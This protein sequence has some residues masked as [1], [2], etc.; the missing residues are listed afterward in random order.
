[1]R[2]KRVWVLL[3]LILVNTI[4]SVQALSLS[5]HVPEKYTDVVAGERFYFEIDVKYPENP[6]RKDLT[7]EYEVLTKEGALLARSKTLKAIETQASYIDFIV[8]P[9]SAETGLYVINVKVKDA[10]IFS[11]EVSSSFHIKSVVPEAI[12]TYLII[13]LGAIILLGV[14]VVVNIVVARK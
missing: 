2:K 6:I 8:V 12:M 13:I 14:L 1:M 4:V 3:I 7:F 5:V 9:E 10:D 11:E